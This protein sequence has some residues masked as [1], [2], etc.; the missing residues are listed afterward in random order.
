MFYILKCEEVLPPQYMSSQQLAEQQS[1][2]KEKLK[3]AKLRSSASEF[4]ENR[5]KQAQITLVL[6]NSDQQ[7]QLQQQ[8][9]GVAAFVNGKQ[10]T[11]AQLAD[12]CITR[13]GRDVLDGE[14]NRKLLTQEL[15]RKRV[16]VERPDLDAEI[17]RAA[18]AYGFVKADGSPD[19]EKWKASVLEQPGA[20]MDLYERDAVW[21]SVAL[22]K[23]VGSKVEVS[24]EDLRK[25][26]E[27]NYGERVE[28]Q[29]V[30]LGD[31]RQ[32]QKVWDLA[33]NNNTEPFFSELAQQ[34]STEPSSRSNGGKVPPIRRHGGSPVIEDAAYKLKAGELSGILAVDG[35]FI[36]LR[37]LGRT[38]P[39]QTDFNAV[40][41]E[42]VKDL[43]EKK[44]RVLMTKEFDRLRDTAQVDNFLAGTSQGG[45]R[46][47]NPVGLMPSAAPR[48]ST[49][50]RT[51]AAPTSPAMP[52]AGA[53]APTAA[54]P[55]TTAPRQR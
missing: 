9:P 23:L 19:V 36:I 45:N 2:L 5:K 41:G 51:S 44:L 11:L 26:Y 7:K 17:I 55:R 39:V 32:A 18:D 43:R 49:A 47:A 22:K 42:L 6:G 16:S 30:V 4:F 1:R 37:C 28:L 10:L 50:P 20:T 13:H 14:I 21:P 54:A 40:R 33:R 52:R 38:R 3:E 29:A 8:Y 53:I 27:S 15:Q 34:Y 24:D 12:E 46:L 35:Q 31:M 25:G 48:A